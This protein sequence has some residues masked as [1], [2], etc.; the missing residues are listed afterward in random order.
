MKPGWTRVSFPYYMS[1]E[2]FEFILA[3]LE[4]IASYGQRFL[5]LY[6]FNL[7]KG[8]WI[9]KKKALT[10]LM[11]NKKCNFM[12]TTNDNNK[13]IVCD[14][15]AY[16][17]CARHVASLLPKFPTPHQLREEIDPDLLSFYI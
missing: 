8:N 1:Y 12:N 7:K 17:E 4:F 14:Y 9:F 15:K 6:H 10:E 5:T 11:G 2:E 3:A 13:N 16:L